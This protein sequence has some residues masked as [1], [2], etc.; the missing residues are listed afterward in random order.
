M[1][2]GAPEITAAVIFAVL[3]ALFMLELSPRQE[4][5]VVELGQTQV[6]LISKCGRVFSHI[7]DVSTYPTVSVIF[8]ILLV[9]QHTHL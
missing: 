7:S 2:F 3:A 6:V 8:M 4:D 5:G 1:A 9:H